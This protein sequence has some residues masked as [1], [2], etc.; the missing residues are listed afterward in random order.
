MTAEAFYCRQLAAL[1]AGAPLDPLAAQEAVA[2]MLREL[3]GSQ[4]ANLYY[5]YYATLALSGARD[6]WPA[7]EPAWRQW[8]DALVATLLAMQNADGSWPT[9]TVWGGYGGQVYT[10]AMGALCLETYYRYDAEAET[11]RPP[12]NLARRPAPIP[13]QR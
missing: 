7:A 10:T 11:P 6:R 2:S 13:Y 5:W 1:H 12:A 9:D 4:R 8:N 3:P